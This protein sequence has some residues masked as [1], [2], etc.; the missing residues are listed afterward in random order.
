MENKNTGLL[1]IGIAVVMMIIIFIFNS[2]LKNIVGETC[3]HG[4]S[5]SMYDTIKTQTWL[6]LSI[7]GIILIVGIFI[8]FNK[9]KEK[10]VVKK[11]KEKKKKFCIK[12]NI[13]RN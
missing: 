6:S 13:F 10:I 9:P 3:T 5:C 12:P 2:A 11:I 1:V 8:M 7:A 4:P